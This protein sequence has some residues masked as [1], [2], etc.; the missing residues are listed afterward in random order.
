MA[1]PVG[2]FVQVVVES[3][4]R[5][6]IMTVGLL[7]SVVGP[8][9][10]RNVGTLPESGPGHTRGLTAK[11]AEAAF[12]VWEKFCAEQKG[13]VSKKVSNTARNILQSGGEK[14]L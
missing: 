12:E 9:L 3:K 1:L 8:R 7:S 13:V 14:L 5:F 10:Y 4:T 2:D 6:R 11:Q